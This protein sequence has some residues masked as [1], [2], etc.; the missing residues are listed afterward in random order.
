MADLDEL[1][2]RINADSGN[3]QRS[4]DALI[5]RLSK[6]STALGSMNVSGLDTLSRGVN[7]LNTAMNGLN[8]QAN[9]S[10]AY[11]Q[12][13]NNLKK[14][15]NI[16]SAQLGGVGAS[17]TSLT[18][19]LQNLA[20]IDVTD[21]AMR[22]TELSKSISKL[23][24]ANA[25]RA[26]TNIPQIATAVNQMI[27]TFQSA[28]MVN[29]NIIDLANSMANLAAQSH[30]VRTATNT[31]AMNF[32]LLGHSARNVRPHING[33]ASAFG[34]FYASCFLAIRGVKG[35]WSAIEKSMDYIELVNY[36]D[37]AMEQMVANA[38]LS[39]WEKLGYDSA[40]AYAQSFGASIKD[41]ATLM[42]GYAESAT[43]MLVQVQGAKSLGL[44]ATELL[45][46]STNFAQIASSM[47]VAT[48]NAAKLSKVLTEL[49]ADIASVK[50]QDFTSVW[51]NLQSGMV[52]MSRAVDKYGINIRNANLQAELMNIGIT[53]AVN[54]LGQEEKALIR[55]ITML[56]STEFAYGDLA[57]TI[58]QPANQVR[59]LKASLR[60][61]RVHLVI[62]S[63]RLYQGLFLTLQSLPMPLQGSMSSLYRCLD[64]LISIGVVQARCLM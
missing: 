55:V 36:F 46:A 3:A 31:H 14:L 29:R 48:E 53:T 52:G 39:K 57:D 11:R 47:G 20:R 17:L 24:G 9:D 26:I 10:K 51:Q 58:K 38:D 19:S 1:R 28:P 2:I 4:I 7:N 62:S 5:Q 33:L 40:Q 32:N 23:G 50:N 45:G 21:T 15:G 25:T 8:G 54:N 35:L 60:T 64:S 41:M 12:L 30:N 56:N 44:N 59:M 42:T 16:N 43:G 6:L 37:A 18:S 27:T 49:G 13:A 34:R 63:C 61:S 22:I